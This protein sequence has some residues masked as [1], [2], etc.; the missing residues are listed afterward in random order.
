MKETEITVQVFNPFEEINDILLNKGFK[1]LE[2]YQLNDWYFS[3][4]ENV[5]EMPYLDLLNNS[6][7]FIGFYMKHFY[8]NIKKAICYAFED[9][10]EF[11]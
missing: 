2:N 1:L 11:L 5:K 8:I 4:L 10:L 9:Y 6:F 3:R 7:F